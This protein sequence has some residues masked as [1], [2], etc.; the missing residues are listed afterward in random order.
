MLAIVWGVAW[1]AIA[2]ATGEP[3][4]LTVAVVAA[5]VCVVVAAAAVAMRL[6]GHRRPRRVAA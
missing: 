6:R 5:V 4:S 3:A 2:R 1:I